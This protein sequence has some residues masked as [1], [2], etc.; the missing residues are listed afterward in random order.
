LKYYLLY[1]FIHPF[2]HTRGINS[3]KRGVTPIYHDD[4]VLFPHGDNFIA[5][6]CGSHFEGTWMWSK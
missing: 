5:L 4:Q 2:R 6:L 3:S 1:I